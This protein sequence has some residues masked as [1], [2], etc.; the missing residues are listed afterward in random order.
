VRFLVC[1]GPLAGYERYADGV[2]R[3]ASEFGLND[4]IFF[5]DW[6]YRLD[7]IPEVMSA[8]DVFVHTSIRPEPFGLVLVEAMGA[9]KPVVA[10]NDGGVPE[11]VEG[12]VTGLLTTPGDDASCADAILGLLKDPARATSMG[13]AGRE[14]AERLFEIRGYAGRMQAI[15]DEVLAE[16]GDR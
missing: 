16:K 4:R 7:D 10:A 9:A 2:K 12:G 3:L 11:L 13:M 6:R 1:A 8:L 15:Y 5:T 14:R